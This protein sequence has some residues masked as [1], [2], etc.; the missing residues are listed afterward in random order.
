MIAKEQ[1]WS[2]LMLNSVR[3]FGFFFEKP[4]H[5]M[6]LEQKPVREMENFYKNIKL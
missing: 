4:L 3:D 2:R 6:Q 1:D 5:S